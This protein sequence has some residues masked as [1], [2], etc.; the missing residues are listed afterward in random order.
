MSYSPLCLSFLT[1]K[2][3]LAIAPVLLRIAKRIKYILITQCKHGAAPAYS[4]TSK[5]QLCQHKGYSHPRLTSQVAG[6][7]N[8]ALGCGVVQSP[9]QVQ[10]LPQEPM[11]VGSRSGREVWVGEGWACLH[12]PVPLHLQSAL[13]LPVIQKEDG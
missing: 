8:E 11:G 3:W 2:P 6:G 13:L 10:E 7:G 1:H 5:A 4:E 12:S 9:L